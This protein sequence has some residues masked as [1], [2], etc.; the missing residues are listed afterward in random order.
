M[1]RAPAFRKPQ[2]SPSK[3]S[4][5]GFRPFG[6]DDETS[7][8]DDVSFESLSDET[9]DYDF[10]SDTPPPTPSSSRPS[11]SRLNS[12]QKSETAPRRWE[13]ASDE[14]SS[15]ELSVAESN[16]SK[17][18]RLGLPLPAAPS[19]PYSVSP[20]PRCKG[21][22][23]KN[24]SMIVRFDEGKWHCESCGW[25][26]DVERGASDAKSRGAGPH[27]RQPEWRHAPLPE[28]VESW[29]S[30]R[31]IYASSLSSHSVGYGKA[32]RPDSGET[33]P[34]VDFPYFR[35]DALVNVKHLCDD[36][37]EF[38]EAGC[39][40]I[41]YGV[42]EISEDV[43]FLVDGE[44][45]KLCLEEVGISS[46][47]A[48]PSLA[49]SLPE[50]FEAA[51]GFLLSE[52]KRLNSV[53]KFVFAF[54]GTDAG[55]RLE[56]ELGRRLGRERCWRVIWPES[57]ERPLDALAKLGF[58]GLLSSVEEARPFPVKGIFEAYDVY[59]RIDAL[60]DFGLPR[61]AR[62]GWPTFDEHYSVKEGQ[63]TLVTGIPGHGKSNFLDAMLVN[64]AQKENWRFG[65]FSPENQPIERHFANLMEKHVDAP[66]QFGIT[67]RMSVEQ[68]DNAKKWVQEHFFVILP[69]EEDGNWTIDGILSLA[70]ILVF[71]K[72]IK[73]LVIDPWNELD[74]SRANGM[75]ETEHISQAL[76]KI[77][78]FA[79]SYS[80]HVWVVA[81]PAKLHK[82]PDG[83]YPVPSPYDV[84]GSA[85]WANKADNALSVWRN[86]GGIDEDVSDVHV[87]KIRFK[88]VGKV[89]VASLRYDRITGRFHDDIDQDLRA[90]AMA[91]G[92]PV[93]SSELR[94]KFR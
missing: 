32:R 27:W 4:A 9:E 15:S 3:P 31:H 44:L 93:P 23:S 25:W 51:F 75:S 72:G 94:R 18:A 77:R 61:G 57:V 47:V 37:Y 14:I 92:R 34:T 64:L 45:D 88:E 67:E 21:R 69:D 79:R 63:W 29:F 89:G 90:R 1:S 10:E 76:T 53:K 71:R 8:A 54:P 26:G 74:H 78:Q 28:R 56:E 40:T 68:R 7:S 87:Q 59:D 38:F 83:K 91:D 11:S 35:N 49:G 24:P 6:S 85:H 73:G 33:V 46:V 19:W 66:F 16:F 43:T 39:E 20:C 30:V 81:H 58:D 13:S 80:V 65:M 22:A 42:D 5:G 52:E 82:D 70:K 86:R 36:G 2:T 84:S 17:F 50:D 60:Y 62:T 55:R 48:V 41:F 12:S